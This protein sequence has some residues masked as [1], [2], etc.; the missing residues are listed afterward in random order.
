M[1][2]LKGY[3]FLRKI[4]ENDKRDV[5]I[6][7]GMLNHLSEARQYFDDN[8]II[9]LGLQ[10]SQNYN[11][12]TPMSDIDTKL[13]VVPSLN[14]LIFNRKAVSTTHVRL[15]NEH[16]DWKDLRLMFQTFRKQ[17]L[18]FVEILYSPWILVNEMYYE[19]VKDLFEQRD[20]I[21]FYDTAKVVQTMKGIALNKY[22]A[23]EKNTPSHAKE[24]EK[25]GY[26]PKELHHLIRI[27]TFLE[28]YLNGYDY[29]VCLHPSNSD[30]LKQ[31]KLGL[32]SITE[33]REVAKETRQELIL[34]CDNYL[35]THESTPNLEG[36]KLLD[37]TQRKVMR[38]A[39]QFE[40]NK[41]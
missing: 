20:L 33:A 28:D 8:Q 30:W 13:I 7:Y 10:G 17:N 4:D 23:M 15:N 3:R 32:Y 35:A 19:E 41:V 16:T 9:F 29:E 38:K 6:A 12:D 25:F 1:E 26:S 27:A 40:L 5:N 14:D 36:E 24:I 31:V 34:V 21:G 2:M 22:D 18:N 39:I 37:N 11:L